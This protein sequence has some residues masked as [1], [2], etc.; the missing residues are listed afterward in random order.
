VLLYSS[1][2][3][4]AFHV[5][6]VKTVVEMA[7]YAQSGDRASLPTQI[8]A[9]SD[10]IQLFLHVER[11]VTN[12]NCRLDPRS[13]VARLVIL[14]K[15][16]RITAQVKIAYDQQQLHKY[17]SYYGSGRRPLAYLLLL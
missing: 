13:R 3:L 15:L 7:S 8:V 16:C 17:Q 14:Q 2:L 9:S 10:V 4:T 11:L 1:R 6:A 5:K 12:A